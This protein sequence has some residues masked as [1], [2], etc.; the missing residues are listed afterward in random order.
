MG[1]M[2]VEEMPQLRGGCG[3]G[4]C[5]GSRAAP[6]IL[7]IPSDLWPLRSACK[8]P[9]RSQTLPVYGKLP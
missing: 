8:S 2:K 7:K 9:P 3:N 5:L 4:E 6:A 1:R